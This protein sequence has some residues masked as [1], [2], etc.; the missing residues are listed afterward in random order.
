MHSQPLLTIAIPTFNRASFL[1]QT[2]R[3]LREEILKFSMSDLEV[4]VSD[5]ASPDQTQDVVANA[6]ARGLV[7]RY[8]R[9]HENIGSDANIAQCFNQAKGKYVLILGDDDLFVDGGLADLMHQL[10]L[11]EYGVVCLK[12]YGFNEDFRRE[13]PSNFGRNKMF[14][15]AG[16][17]LA[18]IGPLMTLISGCVINKS[19]LLNIDANNYCGENLVQVHLVIQAATRGNENL[20]MGRYLVACKRNNSGGYDFAK[21]FVGNVGRILDS[22]IGKGL[23]QIDVRSI[24][25]K[26]IVSYFPF[27]LFKQRFYRLGDINQTYST[28]FARY[29]SRPLFY[30]WLFPILKAPRWFALIWGAL[31][32]FVGRTL[33]GDLIRGISFLKNKL[34]VW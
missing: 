18:S 2:L 32:T 24:E 3:Q 23:T 19:L 12:S 27:Y 21:V 20:F 8:I 26:F 34:S 15:T 6:V 9:N 28:F 30:F 17:F 4:V 29:A 14:Q 7:V 1:E 22:Y 13:Y 11:G 25:R 5:N 31:A 10:S 16:D 33:N